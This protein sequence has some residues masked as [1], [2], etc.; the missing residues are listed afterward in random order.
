MRYPKVGKGDN[1]Y[2]LGP[3]EKNGGYCTSAKALVEKVIPMLQ[4]LKI[5]FPPSM[6]SRGRNDVA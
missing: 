2:I 6:F 3:N 4:I 5:Y 1:L